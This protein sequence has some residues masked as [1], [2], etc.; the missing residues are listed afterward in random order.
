[1]PRKARS[2]PLR[3]I[4]LVLLGWLLAAWPAVALG[5]EGAPLPPSTS[6]PTSVPPSLSEELLKRLGKLEERLDQVMKQNEALGRENQ[7]LS[8]QVGAP[9]CRGMGGQLDRTGDVS[10]RGASSIGA[11]KSL[12]KAAGGDPTAVGRA[13]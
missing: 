8:E 11:E 4:S 7:M 3:W 5:Q 10:D 2:G 13:Q 12:S 9:S 6:P 1:M